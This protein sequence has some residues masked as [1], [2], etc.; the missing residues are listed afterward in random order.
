MAEHVVDGFEMVEIDE[1]D[2]QRLIRTPGCM[3]VQ[4]QDV[5]ATAAREHTGKRIA[6]GLAH[7]RDHE[8]QLAQA[9]QCRH[10]GNQH[11]QPECPHV[12][13][14]VQRRPA[15]VAHRYLG[16]QQHGREYQIF[17]Q[18]QRK[19]RQSGHQHER[20]EGVPRSHRS[21]ELGQLMTT[22]HDVRSHVEH[23]G[24][25]EQDGNRPVGVEQVSAGAIEQQKADE[26]SARHQAAGC[27]AQP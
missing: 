10:A 24:D 12:G 14:P 19:D 1:G 5:L 3:P 18:R 26:G 11:Q 4:L 9:G 16:Q 7:Q 23:R 6:N 20:Q 8:R 22:E 2:R 17:Q 13:G 27:Q 15:Q 25:G 21:G